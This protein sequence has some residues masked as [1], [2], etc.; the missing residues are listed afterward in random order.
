MFGTIKSWFRPTSPAA[1]ARPR[2]GLQQLEAR[3][4]PAVLLDPAGNLTITGTAG[5]DT[6]R[7]NNVSGQVSVTLNGATDVIVRQYLNPL[8]P[9]GIQ[10][11]STGSVPTSSVRTITVNG[12]NGRDGI[13]M[14]TAPVGVTAYGGEGNDVI[15]GSEFDDRID[16]GN[17]GGWAIGRRGNDYLEAA[18]TDSYIM[19]GGDGNDVLHGGA[20]ND[21]MYGGEGND[22]LNGRAGDD[23]M[24]GE[25]GNDRMYGGVGNDNL[26]GGAGHDGLFGGAGANVL[27]GGTGTD[28]FLTWQGGTHSFTDRAGEDAEVPFLNTSSPTTMFGNTY[29]PASW[30]EADVIRVDDALNNLHLHLGTTNL[31]KLSG[32][33]AMPGFRAV[34]SPS[35]PTGVGGWN[36]AGEIT[37]VD[38]PLHGANFAELIYHEIGHNWDDVDE[39]RHIPAFRAISGWVAYPTNTTGLT[40]AIVNRDWWHRTGALFAGV[41]GQA[42]PLEDFATAFAKYFMERYHVGPGGW[43]STAIPEKFANLELLFADLR[44]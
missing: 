3:E 22:T 6:I 10:N 19:W 27:T 42:D 5:D 2:F 41:Y 24:W 11:V 9:G 33:R 12:L 29:A 34:G 30:T 20:G 23:R 38:P 4:V 35:T 1:V 39:N 32:G 26:S 21:M 8:F 13:Y 44:S 43:G 25:A 7:L 31:L 14:A 16:T 36:A 15:E 18:G 40:R 37:I 17:G 28:R